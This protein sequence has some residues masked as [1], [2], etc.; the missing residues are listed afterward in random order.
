[1]PK[2]VMG[3][4]DMSVRLLDDSC[5]EWSLLTGMF[6]QR[7]FAIV[8]RLRRRADPSDLITAD[9]IQAMERLQLSIWQS[10]FGVQDAEE[11]GNNRM[12]S[13]HIPS[14]QI[15]RGLL[16]Q[17]LRRGQRL[18]D[19]QHVVFGDV[20]ELV[21]VAGALR[22]GD[23]GSEPFVAEVGALLDEVVL[24][25]LRGGEVEDFLAEREEGV[26][27]FKEG[28]PVDL[29]VWRGGVSE[30]KVEE[31]EFLACFPDFADLVLVAFD[32]SLEVDS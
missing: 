13:T 11:Q 25:L 4:E 16:A 1:M 24:L 30:V 7:L 10:E 5:G 12:A 32:K 27:V 31:A 22:V 26:Y 2:S 14:Q 21:A 29:A 19:P 9:S 17:A 20:V 6:S 23:A 15:P 18:R 3:G 28:A 8:L